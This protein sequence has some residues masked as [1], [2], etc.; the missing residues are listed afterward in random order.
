RRR[1]ARLRRAGGRLSLESLEDRTLLTTNFRPPIPLRIPAGVGGGARSIV[2]ADLG[3]GHQ[4]IVA[5]GSPIGSCSGVNVLL[6]N[7]DGTFKPAIT[8]HLPV[9]A[10]SVAAGDFNRDG[11][12]DLVFTNSSNST[13]E[14]LRATATA[15]SKAIP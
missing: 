13:V 10:N 8:T 15:R 9:A 2:T 14:V 12:L 11:K 6:G 3:N 1:P 7:G 4:D 5:L